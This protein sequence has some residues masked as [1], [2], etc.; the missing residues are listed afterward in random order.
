MCLQK[1]RYFL[2]F[3]LTNFS[4]FSILDIFDDKVI[5]ASNLIGKPAVE[6]HLIPQRRTVM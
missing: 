5:I 3:K 1:K 6:S 4:F 2:L